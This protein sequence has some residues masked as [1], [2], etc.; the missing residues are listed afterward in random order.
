MT[1]TLKDVTRIALGA[2][3]AVATLAGCTAVT[4]PSDM[5][6]EAVPV[7]VLVRVIDGDTIAV[8]PT[9]EL[10]ATN[11]NGTEHVVRLLGI[12]APEMNYTSGTAPQC[13]AQDST[14]NL[15]ATLLKDLRV[16]ITYDKQ[17]DHTD[18]Y[19]RSLAYVGFENTES[20]FTDAAMAQATLGYAE[21]WYPKGE[22]APAR[23]DSYKKAAA[24][25]RSEGA[26]SWPHCN[27]QGR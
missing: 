24:A 15:E 12:D 22:P 2:L 17:S 27:T 11:E 6:A 20:P 25:A 14:S 26:G 3:F 7:S 4:G 9:A 21:A 23:F 10:P 8:K 13:G 16:T 18:R 1:K 5:A 19:G